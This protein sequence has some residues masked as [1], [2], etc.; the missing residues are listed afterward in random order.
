[1]KIGAREIGPGHPPYIIAEL[2]V[3][4]DGSPDKAIQL[5]DAAA[6]AG[7]DAIKLQF[8]RAE[9]L[10]SRGSRLA[11]YQANAGESDPLL[12]LKRLELTIEDAAPIVFRAHQH[13]MHAIATGDTCQRAD[14]SARSRRWWCAACR[15]RAR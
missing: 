8:F 15:R 2:G 1:M 4:H 3:N 6:N 13:G 11:T 10:L 5:V 9:L 7:A 14:S 12:M